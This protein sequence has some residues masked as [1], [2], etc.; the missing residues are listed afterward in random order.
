MSEENRQLSKAELER[1]EAR[2]A[3][4]RNGEV[5]LDSVLVAPPTRKRMIVCKSPGVYVGETWRPEPKHLAKVFFSQ[6]AV[7]EALLCHP[8]ATVEVL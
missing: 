7:D 3:A 5:D 6:A 1:H 4:L 8:G 2:L